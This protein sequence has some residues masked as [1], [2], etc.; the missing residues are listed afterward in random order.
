LREVLYI[1]AKLFGLYGTRK[2][3]KENGREKTRENKEK[4]RKSH[5]K[6]MGL[7][8]SALIWSVQIMQWQCLK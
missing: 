8:I 7:G 1:D 6:S 4:K 3:K 5:A 2:R